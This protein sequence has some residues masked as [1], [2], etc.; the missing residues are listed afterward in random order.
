[1]GY[2]SERNSF[3]RVSSSLPISDNPKCIRS[4]NLQICS[5]MKNVFE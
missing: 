5:D 1:M 4:G 3:P 2:A